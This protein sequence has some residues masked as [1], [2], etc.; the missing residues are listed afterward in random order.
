LPTYVR[1]PAIVGAV[2]AGITV[3]A[4]IFGWYMLRKGDNYHDKHVD[5]T[6][7]NSGRNRNG[8][9]KGLKQKSH[10][11]FMYHWVVYGAAISM[12]VTVG[13]YLYMVSCLVA[14]E[15]Y[16]IAFTPATSKDDCNA[17]GNNQGLTIA[18]LFL[19]LG[20][21]AAGLLA[22]ERVIEDS[23]D[24]FDH[25]NARLRQGLSISTTG[26][27]DDRDD[28][29]YGTR[30]LSSRRRRTDAT[31]DDDQAAGGL[32]SRDPYGV[33]ADKADGRYTDDSDDGYDDDGRSQPPSYR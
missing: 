20:G 5:Q 3:V 2:C 4:S 8:T 26:Y 31:R 32:D 25:K 12:L 24:Y 6:S 33:G 15:G 11:F 23:L 29:R 7:S 30:S 18:L 22:F 9:S 19:L 16:C 27:D 13:S 21:S 14:T 28:G 17:K 10:P 1:P